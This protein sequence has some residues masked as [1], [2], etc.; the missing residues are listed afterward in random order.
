MIWNPY[1]HTLDD[2]ARLEAAEKTSEI[3]LGMLAPQ[4][5]Y[6]TGKPVGLFFGGGNT[7]RERLH[8]VS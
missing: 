2:P 7:I 4:E 8:L 3:K 6:L 1:E 5:F